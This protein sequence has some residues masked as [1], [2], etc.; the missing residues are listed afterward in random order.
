[1]GEA[2]AGEMTDTE[3]VA[4]VRRGEL[5]KDQ[6]TGGQPEKGG[7]EEE[8]VL[9]PVRIPFGCTVQYLTDFSDF[10]DFWN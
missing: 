9:K 5:D 8:Q 1:M 2:D 7:R 10:T 3:E 4:L 6:G